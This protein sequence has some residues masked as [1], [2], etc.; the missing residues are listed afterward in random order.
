MNPSVSEEVRYRLLNY[1]AENPEA[2][3][4][5]I[6]VALSVSLGK[7]HYCL[8][9]LIEKGLIK[10]RNF[11]NSRNKAAYVYLLTPKGIDE[12]INVTYDFLRR[13]VREY[14]ALAAEIERLTEEVGRN[15]RPEQ[16]PN[17]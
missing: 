14:E 11:K 2:S 13:K 17:Q 6:A 3:Q 1:I 5:D 7:A 12:K 9:A 16:E 10:A 4:R 8:R 15:G